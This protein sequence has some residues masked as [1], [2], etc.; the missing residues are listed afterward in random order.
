[1]SA[2]LR[3]VVGVDFSTD[4]A[5]ALARAALLARRS[6][7]ALR[8][9]HVVAHDEFGRSIDA[10]L[11]PRIERQLVA[12][13][14]TRLEALVATLPRDVAAAAEVDVSVGGVQEG[15]LRAAASADLFVLG[16]RGAHPLRDLFIGSTADRLL[17]VSPCPVLVVK[18][19]PAGPYASVL[20]PL[21]DPAHAPNLLATAARWAPGATTGGV[22]AIRVPL[23]STLR[24]GGADKH[25]IERVRARARHDAA[26]DFDGMDVPD[27]WRLSVVE[28]DP[29]PVILGAATL[30]RA[31]LIVIGKQGRAPWHE[32]LL[33]SVTRRVLATAACDVLVLPPAVAR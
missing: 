9:V 2:R 23:E 19:A 22:H 32:F 31:D 29:T 14:R 4:A 5:S 25:T 12:A 17:R 21:D 16:P 28:G 30:A 10:Q 15:C 7:A 3:I 26:S 18:S 8:L 33:G 1:M 20:I 24:L 6:R 27:G 13:A 11:L